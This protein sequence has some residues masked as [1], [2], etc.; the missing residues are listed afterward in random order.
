MGRD[1][2]SEERRARLSRVIQSVALES[3]EN[4]CKCLN[5]VLD[6]SEGVVI[7]GEDAKEKASNISR[8]ITVK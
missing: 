2:Q 8:S 6:L 5:V 1:A 3:S 7:G 4:Y